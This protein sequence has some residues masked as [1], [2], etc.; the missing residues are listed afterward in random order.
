MQLVSWGELSMGLMV[1]GIV[2][3]TYVALVYYRPAIKGFGKNK[4]A[5]PA[6]VIWSRDTGQDNAPRNDPHARVHEL[7][8]ELKSVFTAAVRDQLSKA[9]ILEALAV[10]LVKYKDL[11]SEIK[12]AV[13]QYVVQEFSLQLR[14]TV[15]VEEINAL[16]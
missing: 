1:T 14:M 9:Q 6:P 11:P 8:Q 4:K 15:G 16:W 3:Y 13:T 12:A 10:R 7:M 5:E 2:W